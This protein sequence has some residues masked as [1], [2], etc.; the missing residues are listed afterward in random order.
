MR[1]FVHDALPGRVIFGA[2]A[3]DRVA[4]EADRLGATRAFIVAGGSSSAVGDRI[5]AQFGDGVAGRFS[6]VRQHVP[7]HLAAAATRAATESGAD[8]VV[9]V[10]G[11]S[12]VGLGKAVALETGLPIVAVPTTYSGSEITS[13]YGITGEHKKTGRSLGVLPKVVVYDPALTIG[14]SAAVTAQSGFNA[15]AHCVEALYAPGADPVLEV[16]A[17]EGARA[18][19]TSLPDV[20]LHPDDVGL[21]GDALYGAYLAGLALGAGTAL[22]HKV[23]HVLG[24]SYG[25][26]HGAVNAVILPHAT[27]YNVP[28]AGPALSRL[29]AVLGGPA[30]AAAAPGLLAALAIV[31]AAPRT[32]A[33]IGMPADGLDRAAELAVAQ[34]GD[35]NPRPIDVAAMRSLLQRAYDGRPVLL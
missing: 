4:E 5:A 30:D 29:A 20:V 35:S 11:G 34:V 25:L 27:A 17:L 23:C 8:V 13:I 28:V 33:E 21:R 26:V 9:T 6:E 12:A 2:G 18:L 22:H 1:P 15:L 24:G 31:L 19:A 32:L 10:G 16:L 7:E 3:V 14:L